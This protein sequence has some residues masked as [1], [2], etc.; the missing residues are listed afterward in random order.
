MASFRWAAPVS[1][2]WSTAGLWSPALVPNDAA[3]DVTIDNSTLAPY[4]VSIQAGEVETINSLSMN[5][6]LGRQGSNSK[7]YN[8]AELNISGTL[9][10]APGSAGAINGSLQSVI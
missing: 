6:D 9:N 1:G 3:A 10:F 7:P 4:L 5:D 8:A 2:D